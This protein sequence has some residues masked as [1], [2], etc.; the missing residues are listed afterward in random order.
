MPDYPATLTV[1]SFPDL[2]DDA[3]TPYEP[4]LVN[5]GDG[6]DPHRFLRVDGEPY[7]IG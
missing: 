1:V 6:P 4:L 2:L 3:A 7:P 5:G